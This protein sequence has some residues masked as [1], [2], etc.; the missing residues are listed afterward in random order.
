[1]CDEIGPRISPGR[2]DDPD[3]FPVGWHGHVGMDICTYVRCGTG[4]H[5]DSLGNREEYPSPGLQWI[6][7]GNGIEHA[8][9]GGTPAGDKHHAFQ[10]WLN[11]PAQNKKQPP[12]YGTHGPEHIPVVQLGTGASGR[13]LAGSLSEATGPFKTAQPVL[14]LDATLTGG[15]SCFLALP[16][17]LTNCLVY[18]FSGHG[19]VCGS[20]VANQHVARLD[21]DTQERQVRLEAG[22]DGMELLIF[23]GKPI[24]EPL[25][26]H[27]PFVCN[28]SAEVREAF[29]LYQSGQ[30]PPTRVPWDYKRAAARP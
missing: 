13:L 20:A 1:M 7:V 27:G 4:R 5:A 16:A 30:F 8:E 19:H 29:A 24:R 12:C 15:S 28:T 10:I 9:G 3:E 22:G 14:M 17:E 2:M 21:A 26:W 23:A 6:T 25:V 18:V 11:T